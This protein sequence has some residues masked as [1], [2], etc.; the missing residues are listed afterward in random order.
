MLRRQRGDISGAAAVMKGRWTMT[1]PS[2][3]LSESPPQLP[4]SLSLNPLLY[5]D[6]TLEN[7]IVTQ[8]LTKTKVSGGQLEMTG[9]TEHGASVQSIPH[10]TSFTHVLRVFHWERPAMWVQNTAKTHKQVCASM[11]TDGTGAH[12]HTDTLVALKSVSFFL[13]L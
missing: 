4:F 1:R 6:G 9:L 3:L 7:L 10:I 8:H 11:C 13:F 2:R 5:L 12:Q